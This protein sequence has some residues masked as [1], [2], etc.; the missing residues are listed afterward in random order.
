MNNYIYYYHVG[1]IISSLMIVQRHHIGGKSH[2][3]Q[4][5]ILFHGVGIS[6][7]GT[8]QKNEL[9]LHLFYSKKFINT[10]TY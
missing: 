2:H 5:L 7:P 6:N 3:R 10:M 4:A 8:S 9:Q 1:I